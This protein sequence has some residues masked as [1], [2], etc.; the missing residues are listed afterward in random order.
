MRGK[1][2]LGF[3]TPKNCRKMAQNP[4]NFQNVD[5]YGFIHLKIAIKWLK[6]LVRGILLAA[7]T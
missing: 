6:T 3:E 5:T 2:F 1:Y 7:V 4:S